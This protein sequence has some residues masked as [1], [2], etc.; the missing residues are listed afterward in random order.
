MPNSHPRFWTSWACAGRAS[1]GLDHVNNIVAIKQ[2]WL[3]ADIDTLL[4]FRPSGL[5]LAMANIQKASMYLIA[6]TIT[7]ACVDATTAGRTPLTFSLIVSYGRYGFNSSGNIPAIDLALEHINS[8][9]V[10]G[11]YELQYST[12]KN[13]EVIDHCSS[14]ALYRPIVNYI[15]QQYILVLVYYIQQLYTCPSVLYIQHS[16]PNSHLY[17]LV[18]VYSR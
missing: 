18:L 13:S 9:G 2:A 11:D 17:I 7:L 16:A 6:L 4:N 15:Q 14:I 8:S 1:P 10:L 3:Q 5:L 12:V